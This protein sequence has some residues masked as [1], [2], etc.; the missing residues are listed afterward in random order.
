MIIR[1]A[2]QYSIAI[3][4]HCPRPG[5]I[6]ALE[7]EP[8][9]VPWRRFRYGT[10]H[11]G[12]DLESLP[13]GIGGEC[14]VEGLGRPHRVL[15]IPPVDGS[16][17][18]LHPLPETDT[19]VCGPGPDSVGR[20]GRVEALLQICR[21]DVEPA[22]QTG[23]DRRPLRRAARGQP[24]PP[25][26]RQSQPR[27]VTSRR[28]LLHLLADDACHTSVHHSEV[29]DEVGHNPSRARRDNWSG[30]RTC[31]RAPSG[32]ER[33]DLPGEMP[34]IIQCDPPFP[35]RHAASAPDTLTFGF[36]RQWRR[37]DHWTRTAPR[38]G[39][40]DRQRARPVTRQMPRDTPSARRPQIIAP[41]LLLVVA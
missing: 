9:A 18:R 19:V 30:L 6:S 39:H 34:N 36:R 12:H 4:L 1:L 28:G 25:L 14:R 35:P 16:L 24:A 31:C 26:V 11:G 41:H 27:P 17:D 40:H 37:R 21:A 33:G 23:W 32:L 38:V 3:E 15:G 5:P 10:A 2:E 8:L 29:Q 20:L 13:D 7:Q 22:K